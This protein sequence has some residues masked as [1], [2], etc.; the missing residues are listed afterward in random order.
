MLPVIFIY[1]MYVRIFLKFA[2]WY[3]NFR[4]WFSRYF[5]F[6][7]CFIDSF[8]S[9]YLFLT[10]CPFFLNPW[11][12]FYGFI[13]SHAPCWELL[14]LLH[15]FNSILCIGTVVY[16]YKLHLKAKSQ[17]LSIITKFYIIFQW[18]QCIKFYKNCCLRIW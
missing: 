18:V 16:F 8:F 9:W 3:L 17:W 6:L 11:D 4:V 14:L 2:F 15:I 1:Q 10:T 13:V 5:C 12:I 7:Y